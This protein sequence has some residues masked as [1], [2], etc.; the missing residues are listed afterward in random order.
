MTENDFAALQGRLLAYEL[1]LTQLAFRWGITQPHPP[2]AIADLLRPIEQFAAAMQHDP[3][4]DPA[5]MTMLQSTVRNMA[6]VIESGLHAEALRLAT[7][8]SPGQA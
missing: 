2:T 3:A 8:K 6:G 7:A 1:F 4:N 5:A